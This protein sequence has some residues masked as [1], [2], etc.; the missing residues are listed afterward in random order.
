MTSSP[1]PQQ[2]LQVRCFGCHSLVELL[3]QLQGV[4]SPG[5]RLR[6]IPVPNLL[7]GDVTCSSTGV[8]QQ[9]EGRTGT[10]QKLQASLSCSPGH[11]STIVLA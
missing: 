3:L 8:I 11:V 1:H 4:A 2:L 9:A 5:A 6:N 7:R 10:R